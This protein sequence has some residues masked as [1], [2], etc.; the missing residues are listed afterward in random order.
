[1]VSCRA[2]CKYVGRAGGARWAWPDP[3]TTAIPSGPIPEANLPRSLAEIC[4][5][6]G[7]NCP[8][9]PSS[10]RPGHET[11]LIRRAG[12]RQMTAA[13][14]IPKL[15]NSGIAQVN[16]PRLNKACHNLCVAIRI[17]ARIG[18]TQ[19]IGHGSQRSCRPERQPEN[20]RAEAAGMT[21][22]RA[23]AL[24]P[25]KGHMK[26]TDYLNHFAVPNF[27]FHVTT[28]YDSCATVVSRSASV[29]SLAPSR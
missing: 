20:W 9:R 18:R 6:S 13:R 22:E 28:A 17:A 3:G 24:T 29:T 11:S 8:I 2:A 27:H 12:T 1:L 5:Q 14:S 16:L 21:K 7:P 19:C 26:G 23:A 10:A 15:R 25:N 4:V